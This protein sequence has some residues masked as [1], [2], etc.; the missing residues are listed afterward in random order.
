[1][2]SYVMVG[3]SNVKR[4][5]KFYTAALAPLGYV[6]DDQSKSYI[7]FGPKGAPDKAKFFVSKPFNKKPPT[8]GNGTM[9]TLKANSRKA[10][11]GFHAAALANGG[12][13]EGKPGL[14]PADGSN[15]YAYM[16]DP[17]GNKICAHCSKAK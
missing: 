17:D 13:D 12:T 4:T 7:G 16:R 10:V 3:S 5:V 2:L 11:D 15:Y 8:A 1:M 9:I 6:P 14:R